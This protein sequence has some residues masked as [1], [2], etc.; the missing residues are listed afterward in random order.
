ML[1]AAETVLELV[2]NCK[3]NDNNLFGLSLAISKVTKWKCQL[4]VLLMHR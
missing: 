3:S 2:L 1:Y 4:A